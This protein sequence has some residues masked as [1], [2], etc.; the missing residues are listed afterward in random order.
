MYQEIDE[1]WALAKEAEARAGESYEYLMIFRDDSNWLFDFDLG[2]LLRTGGQVVLDGGAGR[3]FGQKCGSQGTPRLCDYVVVAE[4]KVAE[5]FGSFY[6]LITDPASMGVS[7]DPSSETVTEGERYV[8][9]VVQA[10]GI[11]FEQVP[12]ALI[13]FERCGRLDVNGS[14]TVCL[15]KDTYNEENAGDDGVPSMGVHV[16]IPVTCSELA[17]WE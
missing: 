9:Q 1:L 12:P 5:P 7:L 15:H 13:P 14:T 6:R 3:A 2:R 16:L 8:Y 11:R 17:A 10:F 4:R